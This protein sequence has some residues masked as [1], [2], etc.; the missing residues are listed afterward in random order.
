VRISAYC[1]MT[2]HIHLIGVPAGEDALADVIGTAHG[3]YA[4]LFNARHAMEGHLWHSRYFSCVLDESHFWNAIRY[5]ELNPVRA[6][7]V[8]RAEDYPW[9]SAPFHCGRARSRLLSKLAAPQGNANWSAWL[10]ERG[11][12]QF[13]GYL[14]RRTLSGLP[15]GSSGFVHKI[16]LQ[17]GRLLEPG[18]RGRPPKRKNGDVSLFR[19]TK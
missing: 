6:G 9:S 12:S 15:C 10:A 3:Q 11:D 5:V 2:N 4:T 17:V 1:L 14:R 19:A 8:W 13:D 7:L 16:E 18:R